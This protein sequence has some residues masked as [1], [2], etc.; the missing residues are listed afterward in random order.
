MV[1]TFNLQLHESEKE[2]KSQTVSDHQH[3]E[4]SAPVV[5]SGESP[6]QERPDGGPNTAGA[7]NDGGDCGQGLAA[8]LQ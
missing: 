8:A 2:D 4:D 1:P 3:L 6:G 7:V 5:V